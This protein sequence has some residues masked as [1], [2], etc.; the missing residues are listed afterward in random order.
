MNAENAKKK[1][2]ENSLRKSVIKE[3][4]EFVNYRSI[5]EIN[6]ILNAFI[7]PEILSLPYCVVLANPP[8]RSQIH[9]N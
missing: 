5:S 2:S 8:K 7:I 4:N 6:A 9:Q 3:R 1:K